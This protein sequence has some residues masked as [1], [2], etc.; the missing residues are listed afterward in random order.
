MY[1]KNRCEALSADQTIV[2]EWVKNVW[3]DVRWN[4]LDSDIYNAVF[5]YN[6]T[7]DTPLY[8]KNEKCVG[9]NYQKQR[10][11]FNLCKHDVYR[12]TKASCHWN[13]SKTQVF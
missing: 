3:P 6:L 7:P 13:V 12:Q 4:Y 10:H 9:G 2:S 11:C 8:S 1:A 5:F